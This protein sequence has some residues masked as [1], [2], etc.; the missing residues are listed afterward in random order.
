MPLLL[1]LACLALGSSSCGI[2]EWWGEKPK[3]PAVLNAFSGGSTC[4]DPAL[5]LKGTEKQSEAAFNCIT[6]QLDGVWAQVEGTRKDTLSDGELRML[7][8]RNVI[9]LDGNK[10]AQLQ[11]IFEGKRLLGFGNSLDRAKLEDWL[12]FLR[13]ERPR[14]R[15]TYRS[16]FSGETP[17]RYADLRAAG[18]VMA[19]FLRRLDWRMTSEEITRAL[20]T[21]VEIRD[22]EIRDAMG[23]ATELAINTVNM[24]C[25]HFTRKDFWNTRE[26]ADCV[27][28]M[29]DHF[30]GGAPWFEFLLNPVTD[31]SAKQ[32]FEIGAALQKLKGS[33]D[34]A[35]GRG[36]RGLVQAW[37][38]DERLS[39][40]KLEKLIR[41]AQRMGAAPP[42]ETLQ[43]LSVIRK[44]KGS[45][46]TPGKSNE[47][48]L[49]PDEAIPFI[50]LE[51]IHPAQIAILESLPHFVTALQEGRCL[52]P[53]ARDWTECAL[54]KFPWRQPGTSIDK[55]LRIKNLKHGQGAAPLN[56]ERLSKILFFD[57]IAS[58]AVDAF[59]RASVCQ[60]WGRPNP[61]GSKPYPSTLGAPIDPENC[62]IPDHY[63]TMNL[64]HDQEEEDEFLQLL[65]AAADVT[66][67]ITRFYDNVERKLNGLP[68]LKDSGSTLD[69]YK[70][71]T[72]NRRGFARLIAMTSDILVQRPTSE[73]NAIEKLFANLTNTF[74]A[75]Y[76]F[77][78][79]MAVT[80]I[81]NTIDELPRYREAYLRLSDLKAEPGIRTT[82]ANSLVIT[83]QPDTQQFVVD[84]D[85]VV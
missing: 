65:S 51:I 43:A 29:L 20:E 72:W 77:L 27:V 3:G 74:P 17:I 5:I 78:D 22:P 1:S 10:E 16:L 53:D 25:P 80:A 63:I 26:L 49:Y 12:S 30:K 33:Y 76:V 7:V 24:T 85:S 82:N 46:G 32:A 50:F 48:I 35:T 75:S 40:L 18:A 62:N 6:Q 39:T 23:P 9:A 36:E 52:N 66:D 47:E 67:A 13:A 58:R 8:A 19:S 15:E 84:R 28:G 57:A 21:F 45:N 31:F 56:G 69:P 38:Q 37:F 44:F 11:K 64:S 59:D 4:P 81:I 2:K 68:L 61:A 34:K 55:V 41:V 60:G 14:L 79:Q 73:R 54:A 70:N 71:G 42:A 83:T